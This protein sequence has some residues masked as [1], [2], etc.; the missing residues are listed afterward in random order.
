MR[1]RPPERQWAICDRVPLNQVGLFSGKGG[2]G[3][4][5]IELMK[6]VAHVVVD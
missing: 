6:N 1:H 3:K 5:I 2:T 4:G